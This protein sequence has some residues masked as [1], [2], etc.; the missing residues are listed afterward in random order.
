MQSE[1]V[2][3]RA[4]LPTLASLDEEFGGANKPVVPEQDYQRSCRRRRYVWF[5]LAGA[6]LG[7]SSVV[8]W[9]NN[10]LRVWW[11]FAQSLPSSPAEQPASRSSAG[12]ADP[13]EELDALKKEISELSD[14]R[15]QI[16]AE[17]TALQSAHQK[18]QR[19]SVKVMSWYSDPNALLHQP[20]APMLRTTALRNGRATTQT[21][22]AIQEADAE[23][24]NRTVPL[25]LVRSQTTGPD[26]IPI[27]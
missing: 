23:P 26:A 5:L 21:R 8:L 14:W 3:V 10:A 16:S 6:A 12:S 2:E 27:R 22:P 24:R 1:Q 17:I 11:S 20:A 4:S 19:S 9:P 25:P 13:R 18:L 15:Q 7:V